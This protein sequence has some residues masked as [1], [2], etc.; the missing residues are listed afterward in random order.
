MTLNLSEAKNHGCRPHPRGSVRRASGFVLTGKPEETELLPA[1]RRS[2]RNLFLSALFRNS[3]P[4]L[5]LC[6]VFS[7]NVNMPPEHKY[8]RIER[9]RRFRTASPLSTRDPMYR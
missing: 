8:A 6:L 5:S 7:N 2:I 1:C 4:P 9:E 3:V